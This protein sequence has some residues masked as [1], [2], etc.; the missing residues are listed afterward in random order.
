MVLVV[1][2]KKLILGVKMFIFSMVTAP[3]K[4]IVRTVRKCS[5]KPTKK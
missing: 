4:P 5:R 3:K 2:S 1:L